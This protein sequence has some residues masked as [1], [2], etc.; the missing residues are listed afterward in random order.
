[1][2]NSR[3]VIARRGV[4]SGQCL[5][6]FEGVRR[7]FYGCGIVSRGTICVSAACV[8]FGPLDVGIREVGPQS[9]CF[10]QVFNRVGCARFLARFAAAIIRQAIVR[11]EPKPFGEFCYRLFPYLH[12]EKGVAPDLV[13]LGKRRI[14]THRLSTGLNRLLVLTLHIE[15]GRG[16]VR[17]S[18]GG[19]AMALNNL[20]WALA[21]VP[22]AALRDGAEA[23][24]YARKAC[25]I[26]DWKYPYALSTLAA[27]YAETGDF[28]EAVKR[29][30][31]AIEVGM[32]D[33][34]LPAARDR[35]RGYQQ[36]KPYRLSEKTPGVSEESSDAK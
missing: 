34:D 14:Q 17:L 16:A 1:M 23:L 24:K 9:K 6:C 29:Q 15:D 8:E 5:M 2:A 18:E 30:Q 21:V 4:E 25:E 31:K 20:A 28:V 10:V 22:A 3:V 12:L 19:C 27:A 35:L 36:G 33:G 11:L 13:R 32:P 26:T 7:K